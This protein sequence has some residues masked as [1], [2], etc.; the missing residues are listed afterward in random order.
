MEASEAGRE[1]VAGTRG[2]CLG[3]EEKSEEAEK[4]TDH[5]EGQTVEARA[6]EKLEAVG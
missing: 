4:R 5:E 2:E 1:E 3:V 6:E